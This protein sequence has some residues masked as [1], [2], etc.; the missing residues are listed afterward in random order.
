VDAETI[1][2]LFPGIALRT[3]RMFGGQGIYSGDVMFALAT[4]GELYLKTDESTLA[5]FHA[6][7]SR[8]FQFRRGGHLMETGYWRLPD[9]AV[10][11]P[12]EAARWGRMGLAAAHQA[13]PTK[14]V[15]RRPASRR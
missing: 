7:G 3:R 13:A 11:D 9:R 1:R 2:D 12:G 15:Q 6:A 8:P 14:R 10:D 4:G 5:A